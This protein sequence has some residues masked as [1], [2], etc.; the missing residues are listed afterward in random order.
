MIHVNLTFWKIMTMKPQL[1]SCVIFL[2]MHL[3][4]KPL[5]LKNSYLPS[6]D[7]KTGIILLIIHSPP[8][9]TFYVAIAN[10]IYQLRKAIPST[11]Q[12]KLLSDCFPSNLPHMTAVLMDTCALVGTSLTLLTVNIAMRIGLIQLE[13]HEQYLNIGVH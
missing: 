8:C 13:R 2:P 11:R 9:W 3:Q 1:D 4:L 5:L 12:K 7:G 10:L 6:S